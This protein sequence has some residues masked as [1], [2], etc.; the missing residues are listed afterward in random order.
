MLPLSNLY[1]SRSVSL[2]LEGIMLLPITHDTFSSFSLWRMSLR[3]SQS[4]SISCFTPSW[5]R[6]MRLL[7]R[8]PAFFSY[9]LLKHC[10]Y[11]T[12][13]T[14]NR[15]DRSRNMYSGTKVSTG[16]YGPNMRILSLPRKA[17]TYYR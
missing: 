5:I 3:R 10:S 14:G 15:L 11:F 8:Q 17:D 7:R 13:K 2:V 9:E 4:F 16:L 1:F 6:K 12:V